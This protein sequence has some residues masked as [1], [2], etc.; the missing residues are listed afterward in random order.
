VHQEEE[1]S[2][3]VHAEAQ[4]EETPWLP[5]VP[6]QDAELHSE[7]PLPMDNPSHEEALQAQ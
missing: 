4:E 7:E 3:E 1:Y 2:E 5:V 6:S